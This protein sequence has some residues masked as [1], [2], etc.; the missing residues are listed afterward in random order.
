MSKEADELREAFQQVIDQAR[1]VPPMPFRDSSSTST[2]TVHGASG[3]QMWACMTACMVMLVANLA[4]ASMYL[5]LR[6]E[7]DRMQ[8]YLNAIYMMAPHLKPKA[9]KE[10]VPSA[11]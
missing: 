8:D 7:Q 2:I 10:S 4:L 6:R 5:D 1:Q 11:P 3:W 9:D